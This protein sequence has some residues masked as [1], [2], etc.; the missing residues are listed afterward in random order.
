MYEPKF[1]RNLRRR[2][3][4]V[5]ARWRPFPARFVYGPQY[6][7]AWP[8]TPFDEVRGERILTALAGE[9]LV[10][11]E[12]IK[13]PPLASYHAILRVHSDAYIESAQTPATMSQIVAAPVDRK[14][15]V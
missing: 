13:Q 8:G 7:F 12:H 10:L 9:G 14:S 4:R 5:F 15:V 11:G 3:N 6:Q 1:L 2:A